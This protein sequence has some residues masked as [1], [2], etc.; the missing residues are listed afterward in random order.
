ME[1]A[2][3]ERSTGES[4]RLWIDTREEL[5]KLGERPALQK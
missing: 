2:E 5:R 4:D 1:L 3:G